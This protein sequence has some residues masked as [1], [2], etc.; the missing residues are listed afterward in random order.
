[1]QPDGG[2]AGIF[3][4]RAFRQGK[5][6]LQLAQRVARARDGYIFTMLRDDNYERSIC[7]PRFDKRLFGPP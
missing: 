3:K 2:F 4:R 5:R 1:M 6:Q 7:G